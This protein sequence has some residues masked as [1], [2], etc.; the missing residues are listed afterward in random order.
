V[1][2][3]RKDFEQEETEKRKMESLERLK[4]RGALPAKI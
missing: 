2:N 4:A 1:S 3:K